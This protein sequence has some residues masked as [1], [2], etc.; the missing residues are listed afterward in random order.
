MPCT[1]CI[2]PNDV[3]TRLSQDKKLSAPLRKQLVDTVQISHELREMRTQAGRL[4]SVAAARAGGMITLAAAPSVTV[5]DCKHTQTLPGTPIPKPKTSSDG[6]VKRTFNQT[7]KVAKF[8]QQVFNRNSIDDHGMTMMS[9]VH[10]GDKYNNAMWN[11]SQMIYGDGDGSIF[12]DFTRG[13]DVIGHELT[14]GVTQHSLQLAYSG[15]AGGL[16]ESISDCFGSMFRQWE[17]KQDVKKADWLIGKDIMGPASKKQGFIC[18]RDMADPAA[19]HC[20]APQPTKY[21]Q[22][23]PGMDPHYSSGPPNLAFCTA[24]TTLG[25]YSWAKIGQVWYHSLTGFGPTPNMTMKAFAARTRQ[26]AHTLYPGD[27][28]VSA[29]VDTGWK[30]VGL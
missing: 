5:Y 14:H 3:L 8:Y 26:G 18:L 29:A 12:V 20:L 24:C 7:S 10:F 28:A 22:I 17:A 25:G 19:K 27:A 30:K 1:C 23:T 9:S 2:I 21:S 11:G 15:D 13:N 4:T 6:S 16:N